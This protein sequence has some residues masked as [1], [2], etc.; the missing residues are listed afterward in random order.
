[1]IN[2]ENLRIVHISQVTQ[3]GNKDY[4]VQECVACLKIYL[5]Q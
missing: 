4:L 1:M 2:V 5:Y 3:Q